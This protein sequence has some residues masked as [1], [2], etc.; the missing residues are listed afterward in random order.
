[1][2]LRDDFI[3]KLEAEND[4]LRV[5]IRELEEMLG[6]TFETPPQF[7]FSRSESAIFGL[8]L[9]QQLVRRSAMMDSIYLHKQDEAEIKIVDVWVCRMR[10]KLRPYGITIQ[11]QWGQGYF[12]S[13]AHKAIAHGLL[14][15]ARVA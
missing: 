6:I 5:R 15:E 13:P 9:K 8:L 12:L 1:M 3:A 10:R 14:D 2:S 11:T 4:E 7:G